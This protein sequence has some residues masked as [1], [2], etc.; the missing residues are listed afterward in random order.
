MQ[1]PSQMVEIARISGISISFSLSPF[2]RCD[3]SD[4]VIVVDDEDGMVKRD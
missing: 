4:V 2:T 3:D 1:I